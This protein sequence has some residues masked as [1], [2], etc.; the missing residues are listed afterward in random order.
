MGD[1]DGVFML[2]TVTIFSFH[3]DCEEKGEIQPTSGTWCRP[4]ELLLS[5]KT[6]DQIG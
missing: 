3:F 4:V 1:V 6:V 5:N 2:L